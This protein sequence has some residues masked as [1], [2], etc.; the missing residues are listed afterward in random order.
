[1][2]PLFA[3][4]D[5]HGHRDELREVLREAGL[6]DRGGAWTGA[7]ARLWML[8]DYVD[9]GPD[10]VGVID[11]VR[12]WQGEG[13]VH[14]LLGNH[15]VQLLGARWFGAA[16]VPGWA[17]EDGFL[18]H[19]LRWGGRESDLKGVTGERL[20]WLMSLPALGLADG[21]LM[22]HSDTDRYLELG[23]TIEGVNRSVAH[24]LADADP[25]AFREFGELMAARGSFRMGG[26]ERVAAFLDALGGHTF[27]HGHS[28]VTHYFGATE[29]VEA[30][31]YAGRRAIAVDGAVFEDGGRILLTRLI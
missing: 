27:V 15:E 24:R 18:G 4:A 7:D 13:D 23:E 9:R 25:V 6:I 12:R 20:A 5:A 17:Q 14:A 26:E 8:G 29:P 2:R 1:M 16:E 30:V 3:A 11:D 21:H 22:A 19:W 28:P 10:G 31:R